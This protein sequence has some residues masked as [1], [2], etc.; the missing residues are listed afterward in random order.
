MAE[1]PIPFEIV[2]QDG[3][4]V[5][6]NGRLRLSVLDHGGQI[7]RR[8]GV[9]G[10]SAKPAA[11]L[12]I[13]RL[14]ELAGELLARPDTPAQEAVGKLLAIAGLV[15][16]AEPQRHE[17]AVATLDG[18]HVYTDGINVVITRKELLP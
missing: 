13:P 12:L 8:R 3:V 2:E 10:L 15:P 1:Q 16:M 4:R 6:S 18:V 5:A 7:M 14:N 11:E 9:T 17:W